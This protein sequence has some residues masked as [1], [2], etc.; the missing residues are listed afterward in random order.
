[1]ITAILVEFVDHTSWMAYYESFSF[2]HWLFKNPS[3]NA[4]KIDPS[5]IHRTFL[6][7]SDLDF[8]T[9]YG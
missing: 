1:M 3:Q 9:I 5:K 8:C 6:N 7:N 2:Y 4:C